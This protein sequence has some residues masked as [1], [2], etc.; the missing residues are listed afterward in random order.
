[1]GNYYCNFD[2]S[3][4]EVAIALR[5][6]MPERAF[7]VSLGAFNVRPGV[8]LIDVQLPS[9]DGVAFDGYY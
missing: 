2:V 1:M 8:R 4:V 9:P 5:N 6:I 7:G 3:R